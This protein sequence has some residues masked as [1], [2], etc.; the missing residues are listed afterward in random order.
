KRWKGVPFYLRTGKNLNKKLLEVVVY[1]KNTS[2]LSGFSG[3]IN[4]NALI[5]K[6]FPDEGI[7]LRMNIKTPGNK[8]EI[9]NVSMDFCHNC[10]FGI[11][12]PEAYEKLLHDMLLGDKTLFTRWDEVEAAWKIIDT[13]VARKPKLKLNYYKSG[14]SGPKEADILL[15]KNGHHWSLKHQ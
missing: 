10:L 1:F 5:I 8:F 3:G 14:T 15:E 12:T 9:Q 13:I 2:L 11:N 6:L 7:Y 4:P